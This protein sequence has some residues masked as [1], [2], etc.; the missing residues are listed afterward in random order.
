MAIFRTYN[1]IV[2]SYLESLRL[3][4]PNLDT[5]P[6]TVARDLF[7]DTQS[8]NLGAFYDELRGVS[9]LQSFLTSVGNDLEHLASN[10]GVERKLGAVAS[11]VAVFTTNNLDTDNLITE[12]TIVTARTGVNFKTTVATLMLSSN[13][14][15]YRANATRLR[16]SLDL[17]GIT[18]EFAIEISVEALIAGTGG[19][20]GTYS[21]SSQSVPGISNIT[22]LVGFTGGTNAESDSEFRTRILGIF[23]GS[24]TGTALGYESVILTDSSVLDVLTVEP[25]DPL[26]IR[27][28]TQTATDTS[29]NLIVT[30]PG[31]GGKVDIYILGNRAVSGIDSF[32]YNDLSGTGD[33]TNPLNDVILGQQGTDPSVNVAQRRVE[34]IAA[35][36]LPLQPISNIATVVG[37]LSG[38]NFAEQYV[39]AQG[40]SHGNYILDKDD[41][42]FGGSPFGFDKLQWVSNKIELSDESIT[43]GIFNG[44]DALL[45]TDIDSLPSIT[46]DIFITNENSTTS[47]TDRSVVTLLHSPAGTVSRVFNLTTG[48]RYVVVNQNLDGTTGEDNTTGRI[49]I[50]GS[51]LPV[52]TDVLQVDYTWIKE[53]DRVFDFDN[54]SDVNTFRRAQDSV[55]WSLGNLV[56]Y[57]PKSADELNQIVV[58]H[59]ISRMVEVASYVDE[60]AS[61][62]SGTIVLAQ[63]V[64]NVI[65]IR[66]D[67]DSAELWNTD[68]RDGSLSG[69]TAIILPTDTLAE[70][71]DNVTVRYNSVNVFLGTDGYADGTID[72]KT[73]T[74]PD[75]IDGYEVDMLVTYVADVNTLLP[76]TDMSNLPTS[77]LGH[78]FVVNNALVG[79]QPT[80]HLFDNNIISDNLRRAASNIKVTANSI[81]SAGSLGIAGSS[82]RKL[83]DSSVVIQSGNGYDIELSQAIMSDLG[84][85]SLDSSVYVAKIKSV[86]RVDVNS[87]GEIT[88]V[89]NTYDIA[90]Y[91]IG[92]NSCDVDVG[93][94]DSSLNATTISLA[95]TD[96]NTAAL[97]NTGDVVRVTFYYI[98]EGD[99]EQLFFSRNGDKITNLVFLSVDNIS[100]SSGFTDATG[101]IQGEITVKNLNQPVANTGYAVDYNYTAPKENERITITFNAN[102]VPRANTM[103][104]ESVRPITADVL[105]KDADA[106]VI[107][108][109]INI[110]LL[111]DYI[112]QEQVVVQN[113]TDTVT[114]FLNAN[115]LGTTVDA[116]DVVNALYRVS[117]IDRAVILGFSSGTSGNVLSITAERK[118]YLQAGVVVINTE[119]R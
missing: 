109:T 51:T 89:D 23:A 104:I 48:E 67:S 7:I 100:V 27:D 72:D 9:T 17:A 110:V 82:F 44:T 40:R 96:G 31:S 119:V 32:I 50:S 15:V 34:L 91:R 78:Y 25:G 57:E 65:D 106:K 28:G 11:G 107:D 61:V 95:R 87:A 94:V 62:N 12:N 29:G 80:S 49:E 77:K 55:D 59:S 111:P 64:E 79:E 69:T 112:G 75:N 66:R 53:F 70:S 47:S 114:Q 4:Q 10:F 21:V 102:D 14:N 30:E 105:Q 76:A 117:G 99:S 20:V 41:G 18:D 54:L 2:L 118:E 37:S 56:T 5:K 101:A 33:P 52:G 38:S 39:D 46:Q 115:S 103:S 63:V 83:A 90:N 19:N 22:N 108:M 73:I 6:G 45:F 98:V 36:N 84:V 26:L 1:E 86:E 60:S 71:G 35:N 16:T 81:G 88:A 43:K 68:L 113:A 93:I 97:L 8:D 58:E 24:N 92:D 74:L 13:A 85:T 42:D 3:S 116:S